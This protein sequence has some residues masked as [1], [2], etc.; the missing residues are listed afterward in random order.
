[1]PKKK[2]NTAA[3]V[4]HNVA[5]EEHPERLP[6]EETWPTE[7]Q[8]EADYVSDDVPREDDGTEVFGHSED[9]CAYTPDDAEVAREIGLSGEG[10]FIAPINVNT[11][12]EAP[13][14]VKTKLTVASMTRDQA[15]LTFRDKL[16]ELCFKYGFTLLTDAQGHTHNVQARDIGDAKGT[17]KR[18]LAVG[19]HI[20]GL[21]LRK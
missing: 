4:E 10:P 7:P 1:M 11:A 9:G 14:P 2:S 12:V 6:L 15:F 5:D 17:A 18:A 21:E 19:N 20:S 16:F 8:R 3:L 13:K